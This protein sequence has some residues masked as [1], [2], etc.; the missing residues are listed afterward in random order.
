[1]SESVDRLLCDVIKPQL[2]W[3]LDGPA[4]GESDRFRI[5][6]AYSEPTCEVLRA[7][8][9]FLHQCFEYLAMGKADQRPPPRRPPPRLPHGGASVVTLTADGW[10][11]GLR[12]MGLIGYD[13]SEQE[14]LR[15]FAKSM[16]AVVDSETPRGHLCSTCLNFEGFME[17]VCRLACLKALPTQREMDDA[18]CDDAAAFLTQLRDRDEHAY[19]LWLRERQIVYGTVPH[20]LPHRVL[21]VLSV[22]R[23]AMLRLQPRRKSIAPLVAGK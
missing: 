12:R 4:S 16:M 6:H 14:A 23:H 17:A 1:M 18:D 7:T 22:L 15:C 9:P 10:S 3:L 11:S 21:A 20:D 2:A 8:E 5:F 19:D 13:L